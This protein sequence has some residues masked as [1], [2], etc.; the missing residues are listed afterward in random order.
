[1]FGANTNAVNWFWQGFN[2]VELMVSADDAERAAE[3][4]SRTTTEDLEPIPMPLGAPAPTDEQGHPIVPIGEY[5]SLRE[6]RD[7]QTVLA[8]ADIVG[9]AP[10]M[11]PR[12]EQPPGQGKRFVLRVTENEVER[13]KALLEDEAQEDADE[14]RCPQCGSWRTVE[15]EGLLGGLGAMIGI[16]AR[17]EMECVN[18]HYRAPK[19]EFLRHDSAE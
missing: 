18:C 3:I 10:P 7:A 8:S 15:H 17:S 5:A 19:A 2:K 14:P 1:V 11:G 13:A 6:L 4:I 12:G 16:P 9:Y